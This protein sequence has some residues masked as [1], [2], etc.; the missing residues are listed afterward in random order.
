MAVPVALLIQRD[1]QERAQHVVYAPVTDRAPAINEYLPLIIKKRGETPLRY[2]RSRPRTGPFAIIRDAGRGYRAAKRPVGPE[3]IL[4]AAWRHA[5][6]KRAQVMGR[7]GHAYRIVYGGKPGGSFGPD[8]TDAIVERDDGVVFRGDIEIHVRES[9]WHAHGHHNDPRYNGVVLH[10]VAAES[11]GRPAVKATG[12]SIPLLALNW[13]AVEQRPVIRGLS[14][15]RQQTGATGPV[16]PG[17]NPTRQHDGLAGPE[18]GLPDSTTPGSRSGS[19]GPEDPS[20]IT[21]PPGPLGTLDLKA[22]GLERF[23]AQAAGIALDIESFGAD[24]AIWLGVM[25]ALGY[26]RNRRAFRTLAA[27]VPWDVAVICANPH[28]LEIL[29]MRAAGFG[30]TPAGPRETLTGTSALPGKPPDWVRPWGRPA[31]S[32][33]VR[34][35]AI[36]ALVPV[37]AGAGGI[38][39]SCTQCVGSAGMPGQLSQMFRPAELAGGVAATV[40]GSARAAEIVVNVLL[41]AV[42]ALATGPP[43]ASSNS[44]GLKDR[45]LAHY[46]AHPRLKENSLTR[47][48]KVALGVDYT[49]PNIGKARDQQGLVALYRQM[50]R[51]G[52][53]PRQT[54]LPGV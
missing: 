23:H 2:D 39:A 15:Y 49:V 5:G 45:A 18:A 35:S 29:L 36:S 19:T 34:I 10:V 31:N 47:E 25:G 51:R 9:D 17:T 48:A 43:G 54:R 44:M 50:V 32:P 6:L 41:P 42:F 7:D 28:E 46:D 30:T 11:E 37:W 22:A 16:I 38:A 20:T 24:Q 12:A 27:R 14:S 13:K 1:S 33:V 53:K 26:P 21:D 8:F 52:V 4:H 40:M 3:A